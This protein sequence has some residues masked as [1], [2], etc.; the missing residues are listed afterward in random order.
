MVGFP[1]EGT[2]LFSQIV[3][4]P[5]ELPGVPSGVVVNA[6]ERREEAE[7]A[8]DACER[9]LHRKLY[10]YKVQIRRDDGT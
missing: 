3:M 1:L 8:R 5:T 9:L 2:S 4:H 10:V 6:F 7:Q